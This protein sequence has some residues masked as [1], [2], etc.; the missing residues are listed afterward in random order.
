MDDG[1]ADSKTVMRPG[2]REVTLIPAIIKS[3]GI[4]RPK[5][6]ARKHGA[7]TRGSPGS[8]IELDHRYG[9]PRYNDTSVYPSSGNCLIAI[10][11]YRGLDLSRR[12]A[13]ALVPFDLNLSFSASIAAR[14]SSDSRNKRLGSWWHP[15]LRLA[16]IP[17]VVRER[18]PFSPFV[19]A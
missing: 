19:F 10:A 9:V 16:G 2:V 4:H 17:T 7:A 3:R 13:A 5:T 1:P 11:I 14:R 8:V 15:P 18:N 12:F 6:R